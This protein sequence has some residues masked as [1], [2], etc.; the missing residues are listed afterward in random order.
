MEAGSRVNPPQI[1]RWISTKMLALVMKLGQVM[2]AL[3]NSFFTALF[4]SLD[5]EWSPWKA[6]MYIGE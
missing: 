4:L 2:V 3:I 5:L 6:A 1:F